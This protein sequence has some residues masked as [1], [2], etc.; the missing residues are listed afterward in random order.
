MGAAEPAGR[1][2]GERQ[3]GDEGV[4]LRFMVF[5]QVSMVHALLK[6][7]GLVKPFRQTPAWPFDTSGVNGGWP[8]R[9]RVRRPAGFA[10]TG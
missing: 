10:G 2:G 1:G 3:A 7:L 9:T 5:L 8:A 4:A 6:P